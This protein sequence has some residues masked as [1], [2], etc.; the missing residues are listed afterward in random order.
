MA[1]SHSER[2]HFIKNIAEHQF[3]CAA[4]GT[5]KTTVLVRRY[6][7]ILFSGNADCDQI[8]AITFTDK[9]AN[10][11]KQ[12]VRTRLNENSTN[13]DLQKI[14]GYLDQLNVAPI[15]TVHSFCSRILRDNIAELPFDPLFKIC[16]ETAEAI[17]R[18]R[19]RQKFLENKIAER[20][21]DL[22]AL[23]QNINLNELADLLNLV[24]EKQAECVPILERYKNITATNYLT[25]TEKACRDY[26]FNVLNKYFS[27]SNISTI[28]NQIATLSS[29]KPD[30]V[31]QRD[32]NIIT[33][34]AIEVLDRH[35]IPESLWDGSFSKALGGGR[36]GSASVWG[37]DL[38]RVRELHRRLAA[39]FE[40]IKEDLT[41]F[42]P[43]T[44]KIQLAFMRSLANLALNFQQEYRLEMRRNALLD[45]SGIETETESLLTRQSPEIVRYVR[46]FKHLLVDEFQ[47]IN[48]I[49]YRIIKLF[50]ELNPELITFFVGDE[51]QS[52]YRFRG[53]EVEIFNI[54]REKSVVRPLMTN[55]RSAQTLMDFYNFFFTQF[56]GTERPNERYAAHYPVP[57]GANDKS[58]AT[59]SLVELILIAEDE[60]F[61]TRSRTEKPTDE[62]LE[63]RAIAARIQKLHKRE[64]VRENGILRAAEYGDM[65]ILLRSRTHQAK[66]EEALRQAG[67]PFYV[68]T[69]I[70]FYDQPE[71]VDLTNY[72]RVLLNWHDEVALVGTL[73]S[74][75]VGMNDTSLTEL[76]GEDSLWEGINQYLKNGKEVTLEAEEVSRLQDFYRN[77]SELVEQISQLSTAELINEIVARTHFLALLAGLPDGAQKI[78]NVKKLIDQTLAWEMSENLSPIDFIRRIRIYRT[79]A[80][81]EGEANLSAAK[82][83][84]V[85]I[86]TIHSAKGL[87]SQIVFLPLLAGRINYQV[88]RLLFHPQIG[89]AAAVKTEENKSYSFYYHQLKRLERRRTLAEEKR[90]LYVAMTR[91]RSYLVCSATTSGNPDNSDKSLWDLSAEIFNQS[92]EK[93]LCRIERFNK[94]AIGQLTI[95]S[96][97]TVPEPLRLSDSE[98]QQIR[99]QIQPVSLKPSVQKLTATAF[100]ERIVGAEE[101]FY[102]TTEPESSQALSPLERG[103]LIHKAFSWWDFRSL[104][105][106]LVMLKDI[107]R[108]Y[109]LTPKESQEVLNELAIWAKQLLVSNNHLLERLNSARNMRREVEIIGLFNET[110]LEG[111]I[112]LLIENNDNTFTIID[113]KSDRIAAEPDGILLKKYTSQLDFYAFILERCSGQKVR[114]QA[115]Y[116]IRNGLLIT[117][118]VSGSELDETE[119][120]I[121][122]ILTNSK[123]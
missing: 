117:K 26:N 4:A 57:I 50:Q 79:Q 22:T 11:M 74:P 54:L 32:F 1:D 39:E 95:Q 10:E 73:R 119:T 8:I 48:P 82:G 55:Y 92:T 43:E 75:L 21:P 112:D 27:D 87:D 77:Y 69:G 30:D 88:D 120:N 53:A 15:S 90:L 78:A 98:I 86:M 121:R 71:I 63:A 93:K 85:T 66:F 36:K 96:M 52:I 34:A 44:E 84:A 24:Y 91:A 51:K 65:T 122:R 118:K 67:I 33:N 61:A 38:E 109:R 19:Y 46:H 13:F 89:A 47:D 60:Q 64:I 105:S 9:A 42:D 58:T 37:A 59:D 23:I 14:A 29:S 104:D 100:S 115:L 108:P 12:R 94:T 25:E 5:G 17:F 72:L 99:T 102:N 113:F 81:R 7:E 111:K 103:T 56:L 2:D 49:Q 62:W 41:T 3:V 106:F 114:E 28:L 45:F 76:A 20:D 35:R 18:E 40:S 70:G 68:V 110:I 80:V 116:F 16:D 97:I 107:L 31:L 101:V 123:I 83:D 6:L